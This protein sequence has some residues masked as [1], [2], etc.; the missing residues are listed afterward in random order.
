MNY[1]IYIWHSSLAEVILGRARVAASRNAF[2]SELAWRRQK[3]EYGDRT[4]EEK[5]KK[6][7]GKWLARRHLKN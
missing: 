1:N 7:M 5:F 6:R 2:W 3:N 4:Y